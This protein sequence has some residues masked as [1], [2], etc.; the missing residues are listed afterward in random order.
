MWFLA[1]IGVAIGLGAAVRI[2]STSERSNQM[3]EIQFTALPGGE[4]E[5][6]FSPD[7]TQIALVW[8]AAD[9]KHFGIYTKPVDGGDAAPLV[10]DSTDESSPAWSPNAKYVD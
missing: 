8:N 7:G 10:V 3:K 4:Y 9:E 1:A 6:V 2:L 5:P